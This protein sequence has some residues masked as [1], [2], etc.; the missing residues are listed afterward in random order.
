MHSQVLYHAV[1]TSSDSISESSEPGSAGS[2]IGTLISPYAPISNPLLTRRSQ[3]A[4]AAAL[5]AVATERRLSAGDAAEVLLPHVLAAITRPQ[6]DEVTH[7]RRAPNRV[8]SI[9][10]TAS[11]CAWQGALRRQG[12]RALPHAACEDLWQLEHGA[13]TLGVRRRSS[14]TRGCARWWPWRPSSSAAWSSGTLCRS[15]SARRRRMR[16][17]SRRGALAPRG[18]APS[19]P[20]RSVSPACRACACARR[21][22]LGTLAMQNRQEVRQCRGRTCVTPAQSRCG[23]LTRG[24]SRRRQARVVCA[25]LLGAAAPRLLREDVA[26]QLL[27][28]GLALCQARDMPMQF[29]PS[30]GERVASS[31]NQRCLANR[32]SQMSKDCG[33]CPAR[34]SNFPAAVQ[35]SPPPAQTALRLLVLQDTD[36]AVR[37]CMCWQLPPLARALGR[38]AAAEELLPEALEVRSL[39]RRHRC[40]FNVYKR[41]PANNAI[42]LPPRLPGAHSCLASSLCCTRPLRTGALLRVGQSA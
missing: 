2:G 21:A 33:S 38:A 16:P 19:H 25:A 9:V 10:L 20:A 8:P 6:P 27:P 11:S 36:Y 1:G 22:C 5:A 40:Y 12:V 15:R 41:T 14:W 23:P 32:C 7:L 24:G 29:R 28:K 13:L 4:L 39:P 35:C 3:A 30:F 18:P 17:A 34:T 26:A 37:I 31:S 42:A